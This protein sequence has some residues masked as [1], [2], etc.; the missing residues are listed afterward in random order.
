VIGKVGAIFLILVVAKVVYN[1]RN[2]LWTKY[3]F[4][5]YGEYINSG[6]KGWRIIEIKQRILEMFEK[7]G[8][9]DTTVTIVEHLGSRMMQCSRLQG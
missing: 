5:K 8:I 3:Y 4:H 1:T 6:G 2:L 9:K 7:A